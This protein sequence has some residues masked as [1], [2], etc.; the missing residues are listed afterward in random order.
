MAD[1]FLLAMI[2]TKSKPTWRYSTWNGEDYMICTVV[3][4]QKNK[5]PC[6]SSL[7]KWSIAPRHRIA[8]YGHDAKSMKKLHLYTSTMQTSAT[9]LIGGDHRSWF[10]NMW[11]P[12]ESYVY[13]VQA[14]I[15]QDPVL[16]PADLDLEPGQDEPELCF[17][18]SA[19]SRSSICTA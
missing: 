4:P 15:S 7:A 9:H 12:V 10:G 5:A 6:V 8:L 3:E 13:Q 1:D 2:T 19:S 14:S 11:F 17:W 18:R 16:D